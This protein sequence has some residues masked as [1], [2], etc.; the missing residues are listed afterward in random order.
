MTDAEPDA[1]SGAMSITDHELASVSG[2]TNPTL[3]E[4]VEINS[5]GH[6]LTIDGGW[7]DIADTALA[8]VQRFT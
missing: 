6:A 1:P 7:R 4:I 5:H 3:T 2:P 8:F